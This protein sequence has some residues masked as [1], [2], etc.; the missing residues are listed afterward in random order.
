[1]GGRAGGQEVGMMVE[2]S[3]GN[4][5]SPTA[6]RFR[7][8]DAA[9]AAERAE[10]LRAWERWPEREPM[11]HPDYVALF[12]R[13]G[14]RAIAVLVEGAGAVLMPVV[15]RPLAAEP[16]AS[17]GEESW[18]ATTPYGYGGPFTWGEGVDVAGFWRAYETF[19]REARVV[20]TFA[21]LSLF[22]EQLV[23]SFPGRVDE[24]APNVVV[25]LSGG[26]EA[27]RERYDREIGRRLRRAAREGLSCEIDATGARL[28]AFHE[29]Y[30][31][32]MERRGA[33][34]WYRFPRD[35]FA[36]LTAALPEQVLFVHALAG[37]RVVSSELVLVSASHA[38]SFLGGTAA[39]ALRAYPNAVVKDGT[40]AWAAGRGKASY[41]LGGGKGRDDGILRHKRAFAPPEGI[42]PFRTARLVHDEAAYH[43]LA[44]RRDAAEAAA[45]RGW[46]PDLFFFPVY[47]S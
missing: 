6:P 12:C 19:C 18:D 39:A 25:P 47:R 31:E 26:P 36:R 34:A 43:R 41:V 40:A 20:S 30:L 21:R 32:T 13:P 4:A 8:L 38:Y 24:V 29:I 5:R 33:A 46:T 2:V 27:V 42:V 35:F 23:G 9:R 45:G 16:W 14:D 44:R 11:A 7:A 17:D 10:W 22:P 37:G 1:M 28:D 3:Q 15:L